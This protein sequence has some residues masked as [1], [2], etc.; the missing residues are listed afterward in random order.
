M[1]AGV[2]DCGR[3]A[4]GRIARVYTASFTGLGNRA[5]WSGSRINR[6]VELG[7]QGLRDLRR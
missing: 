4:E 6:E 1:K 7:T 5:G 2:F 3:S